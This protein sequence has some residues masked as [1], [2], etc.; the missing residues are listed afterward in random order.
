[1]ADS[2][3]IVV[4]V[5]GSGGGRDALRYAVKHA[6]RFG[7]TVVAT[8]AWQWDGVTIAPVVEQSPVEAKVR[9]EATL[10]EEIAAL[11]TELGTSVPIVRNV[12]QGPIGMALTKAAA[13]A[14]MLVLG[15]HGHS[16]LFHAVL[17]SVSEECVRRASCP[18]MIIPVS[19]RVEVAA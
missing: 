3:R 16:R 19:A 5:D 18:V 12:V 8:I 13:D 2:Y 15:S 7:G 9:A 17:G 1:M 4:G 10:T 11:Q 14:D 6:E